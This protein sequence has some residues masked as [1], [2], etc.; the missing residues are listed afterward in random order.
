MSVYHFSQPTPCLAVKTPALRL[1]VPECRAAPQLGRLRELMLREARLLDSLHHE[2][3]MPLEC[4]WLEQR[5]GERQDYHGLSP[6]HTL[7]NPILQTRPSWAS[8]AGATGTALPTEVTPGEAGG[9]VNGDDG[10]LPARASREGLVDSS[11]SC[12]AEEHMTCPEAT[13]Q[14]PASFHLCIAFDWL[15]A[16]LTIGG[17]VGSRIGG[18]NILRISS[19]HVRRMFLLSPVP[20]R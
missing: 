9:D 6:L 14:F 20:Q 15:Y 12:S 3:I 8:G 17:V 7:V 5:T 16:V 19:A 4:G 18:I 11:R 10:R 2:C 13:A 1:D